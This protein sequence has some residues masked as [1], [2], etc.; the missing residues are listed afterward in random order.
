[1]G[2]AVE[3]HGF[4]G[5]LFRSRWC[6][7]GGVVG[8]RRDA[9]TRD[10]P[11]GLVVRLREEDREHGIRGRMVGDGGADGDGG[12]GRGEQWGSGSHWLLAYPL[13]NGE[14]MSGRRDLIEL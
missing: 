10:S 1:M 5:G 11:D 13:E 4:S 12:G 2:A 8:R 14:S 3:E 9:E 6:G 7:C